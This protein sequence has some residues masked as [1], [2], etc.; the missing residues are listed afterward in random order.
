MSV[1]AT[2][3]IGLNEGTD[4]M[5]LCYFRGTLQMLNAILM[6]CHDFDI[7]GFK[8]YFIIINYCTKSCYEERA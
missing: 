7:N 4:F 8:I 6:W 5:T 2:T 3:S 1:T